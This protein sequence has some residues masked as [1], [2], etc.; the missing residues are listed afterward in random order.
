MFSIIKQ[1]PF[2]ASLVALNLMVA[3]LSSPSTLTVVN[4]TVAAFLVAVMWLTRAGD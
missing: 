4:M 2:S 3:A 1:Q